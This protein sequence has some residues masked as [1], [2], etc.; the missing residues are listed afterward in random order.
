[1]A[2]TA[3]SPINYKDWA[4]VRK[5]AEDSGDAFNKAA[6]EKEAAREAEAAKKKAAAAKKP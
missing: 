3:S 2:P 1:M 6:Y 4:V 5:V